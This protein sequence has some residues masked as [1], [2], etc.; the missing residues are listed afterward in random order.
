MCSIKER[1]FYEKLYER[2]V[3]EIK[4]IDENNLNEPIF[5]QNL[6]NTKIVCLQKFFEGI[7]CEIESKCEANDNKI[8]ELKILNKDSKAVHF[9]TITINKEDIQLNYRMNLKNISTK[10]IDCSNLLS[11]KRNH[12]NYRQISEKN[13]K[14]LKL[15]KCHLIG[16]GKTFFNQRLF[17]KHREQHFFMK[18]NSSQNSQIDS[19]LNKSKSIY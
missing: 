19:H 7:N 16:C 5:R 14:S 18:R 3:Q 17:D 1:D 2:C 12:K 13:E 10:M 4:N 9:N 8:N 6:S 15:F 11:L